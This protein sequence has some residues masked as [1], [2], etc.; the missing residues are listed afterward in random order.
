MP[1]W[2]VSVADGEPQM[3]L[4]SLTEDHPVAL[5]DGVRGRVIRVGRPG[6]ELAG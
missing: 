4:H 6:S 2:Q 1:K 5:V 3:V